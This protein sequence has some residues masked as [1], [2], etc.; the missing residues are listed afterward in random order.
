MAVGQIADDLMLSPQA[1]AAQLKKLAEKGY[2]RNDR[3]GRESL[4]ELAEPLMRICVEV[5]ESGHGPIR[6]FVEFLRHWFSKEE[7]EA[8]YRTAVPSPE[9]QDGSDVRSAI[10]P[11]A[12]GSQ[13]C[14]LH[15]TIS[16]ER[17]RG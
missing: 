12:L 13:D 3:R 9:A 15:L 11:E 1:V 4:Y 10:T 14:A 8:R 6:L 17:Y 7:L 5:K 2:V 16:A